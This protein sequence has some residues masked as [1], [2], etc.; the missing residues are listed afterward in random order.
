M[1]DENGF[2]YNVGV[3]IVNTRGECLWGRRVSN[4]SAWQFPQGGID[5]GESEQ[6]AMY[7]ELYEE[8]GLQPADVAIHGKIQDWLY[9]KIP[10]QFQRLGKNPVCIG[11]KQKWFLLQLLCEDSHVKLD[12]CLPAEF[13]CWKWVD[14]WYPLT[15]V[16][17]FKKEIYSQVLKA[18][19]P[20]VASLIQK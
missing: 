9:Y 18:F 13:D 7:R 5:Q 3:V 10:P 19:A 4:P 15:T 1:I 12:A 2:R 11:Q 17:S 16:V 8:L 6:Q 20:L 14:Y